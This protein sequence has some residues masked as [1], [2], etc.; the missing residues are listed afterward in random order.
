MFHHSKVEGEKNG[1][2]NAKK[3]HPSLNNCYKT[4]TKMLFLTPLLND[5]KLPNNDN[6]Y[7]ANLSC[8][9]HY[10]R[11][12]AVDARGCELVAEGNWCD[13]NYLVTS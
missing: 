9:L 3:K 5:S 7:R 1:T 4:L 13:K 8:R 11:G 12:A 2:N 6:L 10:F